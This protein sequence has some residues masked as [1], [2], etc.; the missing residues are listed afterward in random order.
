MF[1]RPPRIRLTASVLSG[2]GWADEG[3]NPERF[4][5]PLHQGWQIVFV[6]D[7]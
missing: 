4:L 7:F 5:R 3:C 2:P 1:I 6:V